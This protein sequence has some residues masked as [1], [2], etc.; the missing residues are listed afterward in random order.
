MGILLNWLASTLVVIIASY[1][2]P[3]VHVSGFWTA[4]IVALLLGVFNILLKPLLILLT[5]PITIL[6]FGL[7]T[8][9]INALLVLL[10]AALIPGFTIDSFWSAILFSLV[11]SVINLV[12]A[13]I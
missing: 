3:G 5:L 1:L 12:T 13:K 4:L 2:L 6:T 8:V 11:V 10:V 7:F 9:I